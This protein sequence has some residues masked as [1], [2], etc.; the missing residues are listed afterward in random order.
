MKCVRITVVEP[1]WGCVRFASGQAQGSKVCPQRPV[2]SFLLLASAC[3]IAAFNLAIALVSAAQ[4]SR[5]TRPAPRRRPV[6]SFFS[7]RASRFF[8]L[9]AGTRRGG[10][11]RVGGACVGGGVVVAACLVLAGVGGWVRGASGLGGAADLMRSM[12]ATAC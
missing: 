8:I 5:H 2:R 3:F 11:G 6:A 4:H 1:G 12:L 9:L 7:V 10:V